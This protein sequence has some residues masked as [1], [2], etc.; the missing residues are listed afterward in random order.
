MLSDRLRVSVRSPA[1]RGNRER[2]RNA[3]QASI[4]SSPERGSGDAKRRRGGAMERAP[5]SASP[6][7]VKAH[8]DRGGAGHARPSARFHTH[9]VWPGILAPRGALRTAL[10]ELRRRASVRE[11]AGAVRSRSAAR[12]RSAFRWTSTTDTKKRR[13]PGLPLIVEPAPHRSSRADVLSRF[14]T[15][16]PTR[17]PE[18]HHAFES[19]LDDRRPRT[20][21]ACA[22]SPRRRLPIGK[23]FSKSRSDS[24]G[25]VGVSFG[26]GERIAPSA[27]CPIA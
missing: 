10:K 22:W 20:L 16:L 23:L 11:R 19:L 26:Q 21:D 15:T 6:F 12:A 24:A 4:A 2:S 17:T 5:R 3:D 8:R 14:A 27:S 7:I 13:S 25:N 9:L 18:P 1:R